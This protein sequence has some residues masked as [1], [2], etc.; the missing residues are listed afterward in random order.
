MTY[1][2]LGG[3]KEQIEKM[4]EVSNSTQAACTHLKAM[5]AGCNCGPHF[6][7]PMRAE[8]HGSSHS[9]AAEQP[10]QACYNSMPANG[11]CLHRLLG[12]RRCCGRLLAG[13]GGG[14]EGGD[15]AAELVQA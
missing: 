4:R 13:G 6:S 10:Q 8:S 7:V 1:S 2:D 15:E 12:R 11:H 5:K 3:C 9:H 14:G